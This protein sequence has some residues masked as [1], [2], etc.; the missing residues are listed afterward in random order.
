[1]YRI[2]SASKD[3]YITNKIVNN[4]FRVTD[5]NVGQA[6]T[7]D[8]FKIHNETKLSGSD[9]AQTEMS[10]LLL[11][12]DLDK[13]STMQALGQIDINSDTFK[14][15]IKLHDIYGG[16]TTP[17]SFDLILFPLSKS[18][19]EGPGFDVSSFRDIGAVNF[20]T[21]SESGGVATVWNTS[22]ARASGSLG[23][24]NI[25]VITS[26]TLAGPSGE[27]VVSLSP[28]QYFESGEEDLLI[29]ITRI[30]SGTVSGQIPDHGFLIAYSGSFETNNKTYFVKRFA[31]RNSSNTAI[32]P[33]LIVKYDDSIH[34][35]HEDFT[36]DVT[37]S[38]YLNNFHFGQPANIVS[39]EAGEGDLTGANVMVLKIVS[40]SLKKTFN[41]SQAQ[42]GVNRLTG[43]YSSSFSISRYTSTSING[44]S[45]KQHVDASGSIRFDQIWSSSDEKITYLS[46]SLLIK[47]NTRTAF[48]NTQQNLLVTVTNLRDSYK[49][50]ETIKLRVFSE[51]RNRPVVFKKLPL[52][53]KSQ[54]YHQMYYRV[55]DFQSG[56]ILIDFDTTDKA[57]RLSTDSKGMYFEFF[58][59]SLPKGRTYVFDFLIKSGGFETVVTDAAS[60]FRVE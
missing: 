47:P 57:T 21:A 4:S 5:A 13:I 54:I 17:S 44:D 58:V 51:N 35:N 32:R 29:D 23:S 8:L 16:Q 11:K 12:F 30:V 26:G 25:D 33:K 56:D 39:G 27:S 59:D 24:L 36:F 52:E 49:T 20:V 22:G 2:L 3:T 53:G 18:F 19:D 34:D 14:C 31:S 9:V 55:R 48:N 43:V 50:G 41:V 40:G 7:L 28:E 6:G 38:L 1:M 46:S 10:R 15:Q 60:K 45:L 42:R 37:G